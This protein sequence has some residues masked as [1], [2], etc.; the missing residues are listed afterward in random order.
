MTTEEDKPKVEGKKPRLPT[1]AYKKEYTSAMAGLEEDTFDRG[2]PK[3][4]AKYEHSVDAITR[5][6]QQEYKA[7]ADVALAMRELTVPTVTMPTFPA[8][9]SD[10]EAYKSGRKSSARSGH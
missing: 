5:H 3:Y 10:Q 6:V 2:H 1:R 8:D 9:P 7:G 4:A